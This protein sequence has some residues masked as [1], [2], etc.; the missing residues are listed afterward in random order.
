ME[1]TWNPHVIHMESMWNESMWN[2]CGIHM[3]SMLVS[4][5]L[6][7]KTYSIWNLYGMWGGGEVNQKYYL[8]SMEST[9]WT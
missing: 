4:T 3:E 8:E 7:V 2:P 6:Y 5:D 1:S 9:T